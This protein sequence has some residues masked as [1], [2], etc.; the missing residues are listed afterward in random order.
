MTDKK[1][2]KGLEA[3]LGRPRASMILMHPV[4]LPDPEGA[5]YGIGEL[6]SEAFRFADFLADAGV[7]VWQTL[8]LGHTGY[9]DSPYQTFSRFA[10][11][12]YMISVEKLLAVGDI[13][14]EQHSAYCQAVRAS[15]LTPARTDFGWLFKNKLG[16]AASDSRAVLREAFRNFSK[17]PTGDPRR[18]AFEAFRRRHEEEF[19][20][21]LTDYAEY[22]AIKERHGHVAWTDWPGEFRDVRVWRSRR[23]EILTHTPDLGTAIAFF[24]YLQFVFFEQ[25]DALREHVRRR[26]RAFLGD[27]PWYVGYDSADVWANRDAF[28]LDEHGTP[29]AVAGVPPDYFSPTGQ[30]WGNPLY[31][32]SKPATFD[33]WVNAISFL[34]SKVD[35]LRLD[36]FRAIDTYWK[37]PW[38]WAHHERTAVRGVW[39]KAPAHELL[40]ALKKKLHANGRETNGGQLPIVAEDLGFLD[41]LYATPE[42]YPDH[43]NSTQKFPLD[44]SFQRM[45]EDERRHCAPGH[46]AQGSHPVRVQASACVPATDS[47]DQTAQGGNPHRKSPLGAAFDPETGEYNTR[48][49]VDLLLEEFH[50]P[51]MEVLQFILEGGGPETLK[52]VGKQSVMYTGTHDNDTALGWYRVQALNRIKESLASRRP[53]RE[54]RDPLGKSIELGRVTLLRDAPW[55]MI[56]MVFGSPSAL[57]AVPLQDLLSLGPEARMNTPGDNLGPWWTWRATRV[58]LDYATLAR[59]I[60][61]LADA[62]GRTA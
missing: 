49:G 20:G 19:A 47:G 32:W 22:M 33:W 57:A 2:L 28:E 10:G 50:L 41:P 3:I 13:T 34:L 27:L 58:Q 56:A 23:A 12:P 1:H 62:S 30:L 16:A 53:L 18:A 29:L 15:G 17:R 7:A 46:H 52:K 42:S 31:D 44:P 21:W 37:I 14:Q 39:G 26:R 5:A 8:P 55:E 60:R 48:K 9:G 4:S 54:F 61:T 45:L 38:G 43:W 6:G 40:E 35:V 36:H 11:S 59:R 25:W 51:R 24:E